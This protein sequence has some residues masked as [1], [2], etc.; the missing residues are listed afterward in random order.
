MSTGAVEKD[1][2]LEAGKAAY[3]LVRKRGRR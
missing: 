3:D 2:A 1:L